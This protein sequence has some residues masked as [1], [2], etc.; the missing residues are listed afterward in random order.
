MSSASDTYTTNG[1]HTEGREDVLVV[2][3]EVIRFSIM[4]YG[5]EYMLFIRKGNSG[6]GGQLFPSLEDAKEHVKKHYH[7]AHVAL[8]KLDRWKNHSIPA[9]ETISQLLEFVEKDNV[10]DNR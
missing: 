7:E 1:W 8:E 3:G 9:F 4:R 5:Y 2:T 10:D 6:E